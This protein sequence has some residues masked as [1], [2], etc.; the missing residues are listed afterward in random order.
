MQN[1]SNTRIQK[2]IQNSCQ[3]STFAFNENTKIVFITL[4]SLQKQQVLAS[5]ARSRKL[6]IGIQCVNF[7]VLLIAITV[8]PHCVEI[9]N[10]IYQQFIEPELAVLTAMSIIC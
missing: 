4:V 6:E 2:I 10:T 3:K 9:N 5:L 7:I 1:F 8:G